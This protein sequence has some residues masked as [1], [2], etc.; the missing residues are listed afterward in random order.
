MDSMG[1]NDINVVPDSG[2]SLSWNSA[3]EAAFENFNITTAIGNNLEWQGTYLGEGAFGKVIKVKHRTDNH[4]YAVK[5]MS[6][7]PGIREKYQERE[8]KLLTEQ[9]SSPTTNMNIV[10]YY[11]SWKCT[12]T[13]LPYLCIQM[14]LCDISL[15]TLLQ[16][17]KGVVDDSLFYWNL[18]PQI[19]RGLE[20]LHNTISWVHRDIYPPNILLAIPEHVDQP[21]HLRVVKIADF[22]LA[23]KLGESSLIVSD[24][25]EEVLSAVGNKLYRAP[26]MKPKKKPDSDTGTENPDPD[27]STKLIYDFK[28]DMY[29]AGLVLYRMCCYFENYKA[30]TSELQRIQD[31]GFFDKDKLSN[32]HDIL[33]QLLDGLLKQNPEERLSAL[34]ALACFEMSSSPLLQDTQLSASSKRLPPDFFS[35]TDGPKTPKVLA[36]KS[37]SSRYVRV[38]S[39]HASSYDALLTCLIEDLEINDIECFDILLEESDCRQKIR[40][41]RDWEILLSS[42]NERNCAVKLVVEPKSEEEP[43]LC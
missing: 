33:Y 6:C 27:N 23:R 39:N 14:E 8:L 20:Y 40:N 24:P 38:H 37:S 18:F 31:G 10:K 1:K 34:H 26:E 32:Q 12:V 21:I 11:D 17:Q 4:Y 25:P 3:A 43:D 22:G 7:I 19:L 41:S 9:V 30:I 28:V 5:L 29:S 16:T 15:E 36:R 42:A 2:I 35:E 13:T